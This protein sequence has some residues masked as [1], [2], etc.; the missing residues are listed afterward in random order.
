MGL[1]FLLIPLGVCHKAFLSTSL[2]SIQEKKGRIEYG[3]IYR[4][5]YIVH[6]E[7]LSAHSERLSPLIVANSSLMQFFYFPKRHINDKELE[8]I[9]I[10]FSLLL[11]KTQRM[12]LTKWCEKKQKRDFFN[13]IFLSNLEDREA[14]LFAEECYWDNGSCIRWSFWEGSN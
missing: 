14:G 11:A 10:F 5:P 13:Q 8:G 3:T 12:L 4:V 1:W 6:S 7:K 2:L 9:E